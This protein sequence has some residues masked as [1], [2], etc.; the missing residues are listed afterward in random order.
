MVVEVGTV[1]MEPLLASVLVSGSLVG[2]WP[3]LPTMQHPTTQ[4]P[5]TPLLRSYLPLGIGVIPT[6][7][8][9]HMSPIVQ[10]HRAR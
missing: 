8:I 9:T 10:L 7:N 2:L 4:H 5:A 3:L 1:E 6:S